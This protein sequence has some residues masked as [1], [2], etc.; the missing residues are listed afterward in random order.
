MARVP[1]GWWSKWPPPR[2]LF[3]VSCK[4]GP[5]YLNISPM[6]Q[7]H[8]LFMKLKYEQREREQQNKQA[9]VLMF[10]LWMCNTDMAFVYVLG[11]RPIVGTSSIHLTSSETNISYAGSEH[12]YLT[13]TLITDIRLTRPG[14]RTCN[15]DL[16]HWHDI[17]LTRPGV[18]TCNK[19]LNHWHS[20]DSTRGQNKGWV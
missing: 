8:V 11:I 12:C 17:R 7:S 9:T 19:D 4:I 5:K 15:K 20:F 6:H 14:V 1:V 16:D 10:H 3:P 18:R 2:P 13:K